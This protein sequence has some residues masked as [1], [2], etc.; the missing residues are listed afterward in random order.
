MDS[1]H[2]EEHDTFTHRVY[3]SA[4]RAVKSHASGGNVL[5]VATILALV[6]A[7]IPGINQMYNDFWEQEIRLQVGSFNIFSHAGHPM[8]MLQFINDALMAIFFFTIGLE[9]KREVLVGELSSFKQALL[10]IIAA[11]GG[12]VVP[13]GIY[14]MLSA[15]TD[16]SS[17]AAIPMAT[18]IAFSLGVLAML[19]SRVPISLKI[20]LTTLAVVD[21]IGGIIVIAAFYSTHIEAMLIVY[22]LILLGVLFLG[23]VFK[24]QSKIFYLL[25]GTIVWYLFLNSGIHPTIAGVL[26]AFCIP[27]TPVFPPKK[28]IQTIRRSIAYFN[29]EDDELLNRR[30]ILNKDQMDW[31]K[32]IESASDKVIS[33]LQELEDSLHPVVNYLIIPIFAF[34]NA[35]ITLWHMDASALV[36]GI[37]LAIICGLVLGKFLGIFVFSWLTV[38]LHLAPMPQY[39]NWKMMAS[40]SMLGGIGFTVSLFIANLS[41]GSMGAHGLELLNNAKLGIVVGS[42]LAGVLGFMMLH[43]FLPKTPCE[44]SGEC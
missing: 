20:F 40:I 33:P 8:S 15:G 19:G 9:I 25:I 27:A 4:K 38:K 43:H 3:Y 41:F 39:C 7:N 30:S 21:D 16:F 11:I 18:D 12:M 24:I 23:S 42:L 34:A 14:L 35:G 13:V 28:Y 2:I 26:V 17:G 5:I 44:D 10:P 6:V 32:Q 37:G 1:T 31:L 22:A 29:A 36:G